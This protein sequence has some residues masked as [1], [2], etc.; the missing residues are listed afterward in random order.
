MGVEYRTLKAF[1]NYLVEHD[2]LN[3][4]PMKKIKHPKVKKIPVRFLTVDEINSL[5]HTVDDNDYRD[6]IMIYITTGAR[7][8]EILRENFTWENVDFE[9]KSIIIHG[10]GDKYRSVPMNE[11]SYRIFYK[12][13]FEENLP[14][15]F[16][17]T[18]DMVYKKIKLYYSAAGIKNA[19]LHTLRKSFGSIMAQDNV[20]LY[21]ISKLMG[22]S[23]TSVT[24]NAYTDL[25]DKNL[26]DGVSIFDK[27]KFK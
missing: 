17:Y 6:L 24:E 12:R 16:N 13:R 11:I 22:H 8:T 5:M 4:S 15:P 18:Y 3:E 19:N 7:G 21:T 1:F 27:I 23:A 9:A 10:K 14:F 2:Y 26:R 20:S 25:V